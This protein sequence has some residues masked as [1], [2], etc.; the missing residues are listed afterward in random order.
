MNADCLS[1]H[2]EFEETGSF[3]NNNPE[4]GDDRTLNI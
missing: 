3:E 2:P 1:T 4:V